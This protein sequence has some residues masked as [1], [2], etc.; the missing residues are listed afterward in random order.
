MA[1]GADEPRDRRG[2]LVQ[3]LAGLV[4]AL[5]H[6]VRHAVGQMVVEKAEGDG[7]EGLG[8]G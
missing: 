1:L 5:A 7:L 4:A 2:S 6:G 3:F 8:G